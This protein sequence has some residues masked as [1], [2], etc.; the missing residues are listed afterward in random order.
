MKPIKVKDPGTYEYHDPI[1]PLQQLVEV[2]NQDGQLVVRFPNHEA[3]DEFVPLADIAG[4]FFPAS[5]EEL[6]VRTVMADHPGMSEHQARN[7]VAT[8]MSQE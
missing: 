3:G 2:L 7:L 8:R 6:A 4:K 5:S 1:G